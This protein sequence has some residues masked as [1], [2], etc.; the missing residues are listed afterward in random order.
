MRKHCTWLVLLSTLAIAWV[1]V[2]QLYATL[3]LVSESDSAFGLDPETWIEDDARARR[4]AASSVPSPHMVAAITASAP[5]IS[6]VP[7]S[8]CIGSA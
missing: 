6:L 3:R 1:L 8:E 4:R 7:S 2:L 5:A